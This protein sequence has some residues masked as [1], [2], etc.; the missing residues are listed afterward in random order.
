M[1]KAETATLV[2]FFLD[3]DIEVEDFIEFWEKLMSLKKGECLRSYGWPFVVFEKHSIPEGFITDFKK[4]D[5]QEKKHV[6]LFEDGK[7]Q[8]CLPSRLL[9]WSIKKGSDPI[10]Y[11]PIEEKKP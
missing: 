1:E 2:E 8:S 7:Q 4:S 6:F 10:A 9:Y 5:L 3:N 11:M